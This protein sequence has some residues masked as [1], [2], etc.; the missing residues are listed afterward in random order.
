[1]LQADCACALTIEGQF[2]FASRIF[3]YRGARAWTKKIC[4]ANTAP[5]KSV[6]L[7]NSKGDAGRV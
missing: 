6:T 7:C 3:Y 5:A 4:G 1:M 2:Y